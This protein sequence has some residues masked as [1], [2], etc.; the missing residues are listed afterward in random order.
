L[1]VP[2]NP[3]VG[4]K[5]RVWKSDKTYFSKLRRTDF[6]IFPA[7]SGSFPKK[8]KKV[9]K[10]VTHNRDGSWDGF[11]SNFFRFSLPKNL[12]QNR[13]QKMPCFQEGKIWRLGRNIRPPVNDK[14]IRRNRHF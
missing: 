2:K 6:P 10:T 5:K 14:K 12:E 13:R 4:S 11:F 3:S 8:S 9:A 7:F 1:K